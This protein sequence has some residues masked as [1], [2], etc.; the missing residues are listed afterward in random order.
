MRKSQKKQAED[1]LKLLGQAHD[2]IKRWIENGN[3]LEAMD[4]LGQCQEGAVGLGN[5][6]EKT[7]GEGTHTVSLLEEYCELTYEIYQQ[8]AEGQELNGNGTCKRL[9]KSLIQIENS[10]RNEIPL[11]FEIVFLPYKASMWDSMESVWQ[12]A[13]ADPDCDAY[14]VPIPYYD[15]NPDGSLGTFH[16]EGKEFPSEVPV[17]SYGAY[18]L[19]GR[20]PDVIYIHNPYDYANY[21][22]SVSPE[23]YSSEL[24]KYTDCLVYIPYYST[25]GGMSEGQAAC[26]AYYYADYIMIQAEKYKKFFPR[27]GCC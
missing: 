17:T 18:S 1:F 13:D 2:E 15:R 22:T 10:V 19:K 24:K 9:R 16:Y 12:A 5:L 23:Y 26:P 4:M 20:Q 3:I 27:T 21:V 25:S 14:V 11:R 7:E 8:L 6:I